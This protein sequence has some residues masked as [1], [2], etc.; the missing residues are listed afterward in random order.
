MMFLAM[1][2]TIGMLALA[3]VLGLVRVVTAQDDGSRAVVG[4]LVYFS[5]VGI[6]VVFGILAGS[7]V[8]ADVVMLAS[9]LGI[10]ATISLSRILTRGRR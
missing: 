5:S 8:A 10:L 6:V 1:W 2:V 9:V 4:D 7:S 3:V